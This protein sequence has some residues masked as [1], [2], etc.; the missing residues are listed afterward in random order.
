MQKDG[1]THLVWSRRRRPPRENMM[2]E[3][4]S[5]DGVLCCDTERLSV[6]C[7]PDNTHRH[8]VK[9]VVWRI[10]FLPAFLQTSLRTDSERFFDRAAATK[11]M[12]QGC[13][14]CVVFSRFWAVRWL[15]QS[16]L[17]SGAG[18]RNLR[19]WERREAGWGCLREW[20]IEALRLSAEISARWVSQSWLPIHEG[21]AE[22][23]WNAGGYA[24][25][26]RSIRQIRATSMGKK[27]W[28][29]F[30]ATG[31]RRWWGRVKQLK[32]SVSVSSIPR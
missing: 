5:E 19:L 1:K 12:P 3:I 18:R 26:R 7:S 11:W 6:P 14:R 31:R 22:H 32:I 28:T 20:R 10:F 24:I 25:R 4:S 2:C 23:K 8:T 15:R 30:D 21:D 29:L 27:Q 16:L 9:H 17:P 13:T